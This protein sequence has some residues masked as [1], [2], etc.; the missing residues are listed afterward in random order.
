MHIQ[1]NIPENA[2]MNNNIDASEIL[3]S[4]VPL[5]NQL[6]SAQDMCQ[7]E[8]NERIMQEK[9]AKLLEEGLALRDKHLDFANDIQTVIDNSDILQTGIRGNKQTNKRKRFSE[10]TNDE[11][12][13]E[14]RLRN[15]LGNDGES[16]QSDEESGSDISY[17][18]ED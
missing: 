18:E 10:E 9:R 8:R 14:K 4:L 2:P 17:W 6:H 13:Q 1:G 16:D 3:K 11:I 7:K 15:S 12:H 5:Q